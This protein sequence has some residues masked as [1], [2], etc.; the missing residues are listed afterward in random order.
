MY[1]YDNYI[2]WKFDTQTKILFI[3]FILIVILSRYVL[4]FFTKRPQA[5]KSWGH[6]YG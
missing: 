1:F 3:F 5:K 2:R 4:I 6:V